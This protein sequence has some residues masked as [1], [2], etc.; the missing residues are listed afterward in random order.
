MFLNNVT[1]RKL[2]SLLRPWLRE[3]PDLEL[4]L[5]LLNSH[6]VAKNLRFDTSVLNQLFDESS[7]F[8][9]KEVTVEHLTVRFSNWFVP[10]FSIEFQGVTVT[11]SPG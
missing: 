3:E 8:S 1:R 9:F 7:Q 11:L 10:A 6:A 4:K 5:G 2:A